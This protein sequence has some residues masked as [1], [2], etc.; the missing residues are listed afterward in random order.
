MVALTNL[1]AS[2]KDVAVSVASRRC[3]IH[4][5]QPN[6]LLVG[7]AS[8]GLSVQDYQRALVLKAGRGGEGARAGGLETAAAA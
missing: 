5:K 4:A 6:Q 3:C 8:P 1:S 7:W 2:S